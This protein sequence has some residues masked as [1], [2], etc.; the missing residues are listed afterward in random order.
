[1]QYRYSRLDMLSARPPLMDCSLLCQSD[2]M[3]IIIK[4]HV[5]NAFFRQ[6]KTQNY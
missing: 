2:V 4:Y 1:M 5:C 6:E 3:L